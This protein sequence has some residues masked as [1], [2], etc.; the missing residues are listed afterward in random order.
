MNSICGVCKYACVWK[1]SVP[2]NDM[3]YS[4]CSGFTEITAEGDKIMQIDKCFGSITGRGVDE[5][6]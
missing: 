3:F 6:A 2:A 5:D 1:A 4:A